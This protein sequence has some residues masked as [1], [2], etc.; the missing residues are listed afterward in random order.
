MGM[1]C[2][3]GILVAAKMDKVNSAN[4][5]IM[6]DNHKYPILLQVDNWISPCEQFPLN[7]CHKAIF[8]TRFYWHA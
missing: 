3:N 2:R 5:Q 4:I 1:R 8:L 6:I 7:T